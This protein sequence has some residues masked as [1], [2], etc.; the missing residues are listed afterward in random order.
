MTPFKSLP[1]PDHE[2][3]SDPLWQR[4]W[5]TYSDVITLLRADSIPTDVE[6][7]GA[8][9]Y[10]Y[11]ELAG[12]CSLTIGASGDHGAESLP[13]YREELTA[14]H[15]LFHG[16]EGTGSRVVYDSSQGD[17]LR[18]GTAVLPLIAHLVPH[19][20][21]ARRIALQQGGT[22][23]REHTVEHLR[24]ALG[25]DAAT[26]EQPE[27]PPGPALP[28]DVLA[29]L[30]EHGMT[31]EPEVLDGRYRIAVDL[32]DDTYLIC[33]PLDIETDGVPAAWEVTLQHRFQPGHLTEVA[34]ATGEPCLLDTMRARIRT[35]LA[36][37]SRS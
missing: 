8:E 18:N 2:R 31:A 13:L 7:C 35:A 20:E 19:I 10:I 30:A 36:N 27:N 3:V 29:L 28:D 32:L 24:H 4:L 14:W 6:I 21:T 16:P 15:V 9:Y 23:V 34:P 12:G 17:Q 11:A 5:G 37:A 26:P 22:A 33:L 25:L 1:F